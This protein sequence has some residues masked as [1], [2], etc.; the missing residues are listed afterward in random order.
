MRVC[1]S[2]FFVT[3]LLSKRWVNDR[4]YANFQGTYASKV[5]CFN[6][7]IQFEIFLSVFVECCMGV[8]DSLWFF[9]AHGVIWFT[10][11]HRGISFR[12]SLFDWELVFPKHNGTEKRVACLPRTAND[13]KRTWKSDLKR[14]WKRISV[15]ETLMQLSNARNLRDLLFSKPKKAHLS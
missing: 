6:T 2:H 8:W 13:Q 3:R 7:E 9:D 5:R 14:I 10:I 4:F 1:F 12:E 11:S 15:Y